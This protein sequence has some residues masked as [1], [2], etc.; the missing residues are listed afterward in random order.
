MPKR[1]P[2]IPT[3]AGSNQLLRPVQGHVGILEKHRIHDNQSS[4]SGIH[5]NSSDTCDTI[6]RRK[7]EHQRRQMMVYH[8]DHGQDITSSSGPDDDGTDDDNFD[9]DGDFEEGTERDSDDSSQDERDIRDH[10]EQDVAW[11]KNFNGNT[12]EALYA[13]FSR[14]ATSKPSTVAVAKANQRRMSGPQSYVRIT[15]END[16]EIDLIHRKHQVKLRHPNGGAPRK[17]N[18]YQEKRRSDTAIEYMMQR[19]NQLNELKAR[20]ASK[21]SIDKRIAPVHIRRQR[22]TS[23]AKDFKGST[24]A[25]KSKKQDALVSALK[26]R[27]E[28][29]DG[30]RQPPHTVITKNVRQNEVLSSD[31]EAEHPQTN[32]K[33]SDFDYQ[34]ARSLERKAKRRTKELKQNIADAKMDVKEAQLG[35]FSMKLRTRHAQIEERHA[36]LMRRRMALKKAEEDLNALEANLD[37][38][39]EEHR[40]RERRIRNRERRIKQE[41]AG[42]KLKEESLRKREMAISENLSNLDK[43][44]QLVEEKEETANK[45]N[46]IIQARE[47]LHGQSVQKPEPKQ[48]TKSR[49]GLGK[50]I[51]RRNKEKNEKPGQDK[52]NSKMKSPKSS[53][54]SNT[55]P[56]S[57]KLAQ[58][59]NHHL[60]NNNIINNHV[61]FNTLDK[62]QA[63]KQKPMPKQTPNHTHIVKPA[64]NN[65]NSEKQ[66]VMGWW[67]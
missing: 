52:S 49:I 14:G 50:L 18:E 8:N 63:Q 25:L 51:T 22:S 33:V 41:E 39:E 47:Y 46:T 64:E 66:N 48:K 38:Q 54:S 53:S 60:N 20:R 32:N 65:N 59:Q 44:R 45:M 31:S 12:N 34:K 56:K 36:K 3:F 61:K 19:R 27:F 10:Y 35:E 5:S 21:E 17:T 29:R 6:D 4:S 23:G 28:P 15:R 13:K 2:I 24:T 37:D 11:S 57:A 9:N 58:H 55:L 30:Y 67:I 62:K 16:E 43:R 1:A 40:G 7:R 42:I 26:A